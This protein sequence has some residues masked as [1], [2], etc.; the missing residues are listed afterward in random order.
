V[1][2]RDEIDHILFHI[3]AEEANPRASQSPGVAG[4]AQMVR[5]L[6][7][8]VK[9]GTGPFNRKNLIRELKNRATDAPSTFAEMMVALEF[10]D[11]DDEG[12]KI[13]RVLTEWVGGRELG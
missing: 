4:R 1:A 5:A 12:Q 9:R 7:A 13:R 3:D 6:L 8:P 2:I 11:E 10:L